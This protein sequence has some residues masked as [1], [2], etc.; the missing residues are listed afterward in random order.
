[1][2]VQM[3]SMATKAAANQEA[4]AVS[5]WPLPEIP[6]RPPRRPSTRRPW[7]LP[8]DGRKRTKR[9]LNQPIQGNHGTRLKAT[10]ARRFSTNG[11][12]LDV[13]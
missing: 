9:C 4:S 6:H 5:S 2:M 10:M 12:W 11:A 1:M 13:V 7:R 8:T 3:V